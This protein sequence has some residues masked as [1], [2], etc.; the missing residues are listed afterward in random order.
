MKKIKLGKDALKLAILTLITV[1][2]WI[3]FDV[4]RA[5]TKSDIPKILQRQIAPL[6]PKLDWE[7]VERLK[8]KGTV[9]EEELKKVVVPETTP[10]PEPTPTIEVTPSPEATLSPEASPSPTVTPIE[11]AAESGT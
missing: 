6:N 7:T 3:G 2:T 5:L 10:T 1:I 9:G 8:T 11:E 4:Y